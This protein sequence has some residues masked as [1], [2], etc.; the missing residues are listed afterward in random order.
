MTQEELY[1]LAFHSWE[2][3]DGCTEDDRMFWING[4]MR[5]ANLFGD[6]ESLPS[7]QQLEEKGRLMGEMFS[8]LFN[9]QQNLSSKYGQIISDNFDDLI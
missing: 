5:A 9:N 3:C 1:K 4:F 6:I 2:D 7:P 8:K